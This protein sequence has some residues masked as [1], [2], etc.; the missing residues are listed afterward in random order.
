MNSSA[1][2][3]G[4]LSSGYTQYPDDS[5]FAIFN[6][7]CSHITAQAQLIVHRENDS[8]YYTYIRKIGQAKFIALAIVFYGCYTSRIKEIFS[9][10]EEEIEKILE[11]GI[12]I[13]FTEQGEISSNMESIINEEEEARAICERLQNKADAIR[14]VRKLPP[15]DF[16][17]AITSQKIFKYTDPESEIASASCRIAYTIVLKDQ[18]F[19]TIRT[20]NYKNVLKNLSANRD[21]LAQENAELKETNRKILRKKNQFEK[22]IILTIA[23]VFCLIGLY[24]LFSNLT[25]TNEKLENA[26]NI[27][28]QNT[29][30]IEQQNLNISQLNDTVYNLHNS[31]R[32]LATDL[33]KEKQSREKSDSTLREIFEYQP[34]VLTDSWVSSSNFN[35]KYYCPSDTTITLTLAAINQSTG[36]IISNS[37]TIDLAKDKGEQCLY[38]KNTLNTS[39]YYYVII[40]YNG[41]IISGKYW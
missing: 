7:I 23:V 8:M 40:L 31:I 34:F 6:N 13:H 35:F 29:I 3:F 22:V 12:F 33:Q 41:R 9:I 11:R 1:Y 32:S 30:T 26:E 14:N 38:F 20:T 28:K 39:Y 4:K 15:V 17:V 18:D 37:H 19:D 21:A 10:F 5:A 27:N 36:G 24:I 2:I 16:S 25:D